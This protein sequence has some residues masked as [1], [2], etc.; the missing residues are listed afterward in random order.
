MLNQEGKK[1]YEQGNFS[2]ATEYFEEAAKLASAFGINNVYVTTSLNNLALMNQLMGEYSK[3]ESLYRQVLDIQKSVSGKK[4]SVYAMNLGNLAE[5]YKKMKEYEKAESLYRQAL[6]ITKKK[7]FRKSNPDYVLHLNNLAVLYQDMG[8]YSKAE[9]LYR[10]ALDIREKAVGKEHPDYVLHLNNLA[11]LYQD[12][13]EYAKA[14]PLYRQTLDIREKVVGREHPDYA[15]SFYNLIILYDKMGNP[16][17][18]LQIVYPVLIDSLRTNDPETAFSI[19]EKGLDIVNNEEHK[20]IMAMIF[21]QIGVKIVNDAQKKLESEKKGGTPDTINEL[22]RGISFQV[23]AAELGSTEAQEKMAVL[24]N[25]A[26][27]KI[28]KDAQKKLELEEKGGTP[29]TINELSQGMSFLKKAAELGSTEAQKNYEQALII[30]LKLASITLEQVELE[31]LDLKPPVLNLITQAKEVEQLGKYDDAIEL[32]E[33]ALDIASGQEEAG[34]KKQFAK[35][36]NLRAVQNLNRSIEKLKSINERHQQQIKK[37]MEKFLKGNTLLDSIFRSQENARA[38]SGNC[39]K[40]GKTSSCE[41]D[42]P[43]YGEICLCDKHYSELRSIIERKP[44]DDFM[45]QV[46]HSIEIDLNKAIDFDPNF[47]QARKNLEYVRSLKP[48]FPLYTSIIVAN[49]E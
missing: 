33:S 11:V 44:P 47:E 26:G 20:S 22:T 7:I 9:P 2:K 1:L 21:N 10:Q 16:L 39:L 36:L 28:V 15:K 42:L 4:S 6:D 5:L 18:A 12:M 17:K 43:E 24:F 8:E 19:L 23:K 32:Y 48:Q 29:D 40:C 14:E 46:L 30:I 27:V 45:S 37:D 49:E 13:G 41:I 35:C 38:A 3:A 31:A 34:I 25:Q